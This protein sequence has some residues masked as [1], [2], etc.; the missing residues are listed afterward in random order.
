MAQGAKTFENLNGMTISP[1]YF[2]AIDQGRQKIA[3]NIG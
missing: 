2:Q 1:T 3:E